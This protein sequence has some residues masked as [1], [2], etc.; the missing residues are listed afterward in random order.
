MDGRCSTGPGGAVKIE[1]IGSARGLFEH[2]DL[3]LLLHKRIR[4]P[5]YR[6]EGSVF[7]RGPLTAAG[8]SMEKR[9]GIAAFAG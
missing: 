3:P 4:V 1:L 9:P 2:A 7:A 8:W 6:G 5:F